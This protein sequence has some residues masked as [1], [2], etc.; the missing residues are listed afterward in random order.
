MP[1]LSR[2]ESRFLRHRLS[3]VRH[4]TLD[5]GGPGVVRIHLVP[6]RRS[7]REVPYIAILNG[8]DILPLSV[9][10]AILLVCLID[11]LQP[12]EGQELQTGQWNAVVEQAVGDTRTV[13]SHTP[14]EQIRA[15]LSAMVEA[16]Q[17]IAQGRTPQLP[18]ERMDLGQYAP[19]MLAPHRMDLM[20]S[21]MQKDGAWQCNQKC[22]HCYAANQPY[23]KTAELDTDQWL[24]VLQKC[25]DAGIPQ[26]TFTG[27]EP[28]LRND[29]VKLVRA[30]QWFVT[31]LNTNG[32]LLTIP[33]C[34]ELYEASLDAVQ[35][36]LYSADPAVHNA[37]VGAPGFE[38]T[39]SG[40]RNAVAAGL[41]VSIN[42]PLCRR[43]CDLAATLAF[44]HSLGV[45]YCTCSGLIPAGGAVTGSSVS[46]RLSTAEL[47]DVLR[48]G[49]QYADANGMELE[50]TSPGWLDDRTL[51]N[52]GFTLIPS[53]GACLS[54]MAVAP[55]GTVLPCQSWLSG[56]GL[57]NILHQPWSRIWNSTDC[58]RIR[59]VSARMEHICQLGDPRRKEDA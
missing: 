10:W 50:F 49:K 30:A 6:C 22:L 48:Q 29:L 47:T 52:L 58:R 17:D 14:A 41:N 57:G 25:R 46:T 23:G 34:R 21:S 1:F 51:E 13:Y 31:R 7:L 54:N 44:V 16:F 56:P 59:H 15:D 39:V 35:V 3:V 32:R 53:C 2:A 5:P 9:S 18:V 11:A 45:R 55:D 38:D 20:I 4:V 40:I 12:F 19:H 33:L 36:T 43:N 42:T 26:V 37:L 27:G 28:T 24:A 8:R